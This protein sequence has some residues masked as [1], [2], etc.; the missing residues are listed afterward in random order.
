[1]ANRAGVSRFG[2]GQSTLD[3]RIGQQGDLSV[4]E[5][6]GRYYE[7]AVRRNIF[8]SHSKVRATSLGA[9][10]QIGNILWNPPDSGVNLVLTKWAS[11]VSVS[12]AT[13]TGFCLGFGYQ[14][15]SPTSVTVADVTGSTFIL[16]TG[17]SNTVLL[18]SKA[19]AYSIATLLFAP[20]D[21][22][23]L[24]HNTA[25]INTVGGENLS[26]DFE[27][28]IIIPPG[29]LVTIN[30]IGAATAAAAHTSTLFWEEV[31]LL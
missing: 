11:M 23:L 19:K 8:F 24:H 6:H 16:L 15:T 30:A 13:C 21:G 28:S 12:S 17:A 18:N 25:A 5:L 7:Q 27:G 29:G 31:P 1:M 2:D 3:Q 9:T 20:I 4:S 14:T 22:P 10:S 26:G